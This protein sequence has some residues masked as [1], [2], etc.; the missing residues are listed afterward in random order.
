VPSPPLHI[1]CP[2]PTDGEVPCALQVWISDNSSRQAYITL[3]PY[4]DE[5]RAAGDAIDTLLCQTPATLFHSQSEPPADEPRHAFTEAS[6]QTKACLSNPNASGLELKNNVAWHNERHAGIWGGSCTCPDGRRYQVGDSMDHCDSLA[7]HGG[8]S[9]RCI[10]YDGPWSGR[11]VDCGTSAAV[12]ELTIYARSASGRPG[13]RGA[14]IATLSAH[15][16]A[17]QPR[18]RGQACMESGL[19]SSLC[20]GV[21]TL[22][23]GC[24]TRVSRKTD[25]VTWTLS[26]GE[27]ITAQVGRPP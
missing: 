27:Q 7:C 20:F 26:G 9:G 25:S 22:W 16:D 19:F 5:R 15:D 10:R 12:A 17:S 18:W 4:E 1:H 14:V 21:G 11:G 8:S 13:A 24:A 3:S 6:P 2:V 23:A